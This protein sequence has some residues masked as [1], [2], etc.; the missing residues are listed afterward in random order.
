MTS[1][2]SN[3]TQLHPAKATGTHP[4][5][6]PGLQQSPAPLWMFPLKPTAWR[7]LFVLCRQLNAP[8]NP[9]STLAP[10]VQTTPASSQPPRKV[11]PDMPGC[12][13]SLQRFPRHLQVVVPLGLGQAVKVEQ[14]GVQALVIVPDLGRGREGERSGPC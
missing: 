5:T 12:S 9:T 2:K 6:S 1:P 14:A 11:N 10:G 13:R 8:R 4:E 7:D 3:G